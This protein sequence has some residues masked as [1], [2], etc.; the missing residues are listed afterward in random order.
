MAWL[1]RLFIR[2][3]MLTAGCVLFAVIFNAARPNGIDLV[4]PRPYDIYVPCPESETGAESVSAEQL[5]GAA[6]MLYLDVRPETD[7]RREHIKGAV[8]FPYPML[9][10]P[11]ADRVEVLKQRG[12]PIVTYDGG[13]R[14]MTGEMM[15]ALLTEL[16]VP[17]VTHLEGGLE[18]WHEQGGDIQGAGSGSATD[19]GRSC[20]GLDAGSGCGEAPSGEESP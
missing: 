11:P 6:N 2:S 7:F 14:D 8:S 17:N 3:V 20:G 10:D 13:G 19:D 12:V 5:Q 9:G 18:A 1:I 15:A 4:A 16:G